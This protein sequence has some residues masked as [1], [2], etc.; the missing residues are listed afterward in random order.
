MAANSVVNMTLAGIPH[1]CATYSSCDKNVGASSGKEVPTITQDCP[2][3]MMTYILRPSH[4][5]SRLPPGCP[6]KGPGFQKLPDLTVPK[7]F[8]KTQ[9]CRRT[10]PEAGSPA[11]RGGGSISRYGRQVKAA[12]VLHRVPLR[13]L[14]FPKALG[15]VP[16][17]AKG[18]PFCSKRTIYSNKIEVITKGRAP[19]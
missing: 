4:W 17:L 2:S 18:E 9:F 16:S 12:P 14:L 13:E 19:L 1:R 3:Q 7:H 10:D 6:G 8:V 11:V 5:L 15:K